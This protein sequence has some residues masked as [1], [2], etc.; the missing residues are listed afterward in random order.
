MTEKKTRV[1]RT[2]DRR[3]SRPPAVDSNQLYSIEECAAALD[4]SRAG[5][6]NDIAAGKLTIIHDGGRRKIAGAEIIRITRE[7][8]E[9]AYSSRGQSEARTEEPPPGAA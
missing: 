8:I 5:I 9:R 1:S 6:Y 2:A 4:K 3:A 7:M